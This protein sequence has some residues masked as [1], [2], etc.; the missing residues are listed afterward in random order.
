M[1]KREN[2]FNRRMRCAAVGFVASCLVIMMAC[3]GSTSSVLISP[4]AALLAPGQTFQFTIVRTGNDAASGRPQPVLLVN[5]VVGGSPSTGTIT[6]GG[7]YT[8]PSNASAPPIII[9]IQGRSSSAAVTLFSPSRFTPGSVVATRNPLVASYSI[10]IPAGASAQ[11]QFGLDTSYGFPT[12]IVQAPPAGG[13]TTILI[14]GMRAS[15][16]Y[17][18]Q[19][20][21][22]LYNGSQV[23]DADH[24]FTTGSIPADRLPS[25]TTQTSGVGT[26]S[27]GVELLSLAPDN[28]GGN[29]LS[30][31]ATDLEGNVIWYYDLESTFFPEPVKPLPNGHMLVVAMP[32]GGT[33]VASEIREVDLAGNITNRITLNAVNQALKGIASF[34]AQS[35]THD[36]A[37]LPNGHWILLVSFPKTIKNAPGI[38]AGTQMVGDAL[39][40]WDVQQG[41]AVWTWSTFDHLDLTHAPYGFA[42]WTHSNAIIFSPDDGNLILSMRNQNWLIKINYSDGTGDGSVQWRLGP[43][44]DFTLP[45]GEEPLEWNYGQH[46][47]TIV[48]PNSSGVFSL[49]LFDNGNSRFM[50]SNDDICGTA[51][52]GAC[53]SSVSIF[54][55]D[56]FARTASV[57]WD[58][59]LLPSY[60]GCCGDALL[61]PNGNAEFDIAADVN[62]PNFCHIQEVTQT[63]TPELVW[64]MDIQGQ[65]AYRGLRIPSLYP[66]Q[67]WPATA[68]SSSSHVLQVA[69]SANSGAGVR[70]GFLRE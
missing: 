9:G 59:D 49:M 58:D 35:F 18:M 31:V 36:V 69:P 19:A 33:T 62:T 48:S 27:P 68:Q 6:P 40:D 50:D 65:L 25:I 10:V 12:S 55:L 17:H 23:L 53:Y 22:D 29:L 66:G 24:A 38:P 34:Q 1:F 32:L 56:E 64:K 60:S 5:G 51:G 67:V 21:V 37:V 57:L 45:S 70:P 4:S 2:M 63:Q 39:I 28:P 3:G 44:G 47:P 11:V 43:G 20:V 41:T 42:D 52:V 16:T 26:L 13:T 30:T 15:T 46:Y 61:L 54:Q 8:A 7:L 14:A